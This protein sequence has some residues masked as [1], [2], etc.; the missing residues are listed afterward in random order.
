MKDHLA[1]RAR[2]SRRLNSEGG[3]KLASFLLAC[4]GLKSSSAQHQRLHQ[5]DRADLN[6]LH[7]QTPALWS[8]A[9]SPM[10]VSCFCKYIDADRASDVS[11][12]KPA[13]YQV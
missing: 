8:M 7:L 1:S 9:Y 12:G 2:R 11:G 13:L 5:T 4:I 10:A 6:A 3:G